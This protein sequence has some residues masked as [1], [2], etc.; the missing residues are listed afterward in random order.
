M[1][2][3]KIKENFLNARKGYVKFLWKNELR[4]K[5]KQERRSKVNISQLWLPGWISIWKEEK[6][7]PWKW[8]N[9]YFNKDVYFLRRAPVYLKRLCLYINNLKKKTET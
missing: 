6:R 9:D 5:L 1:G 7:V 8:D 3:L 4:K 2:Y